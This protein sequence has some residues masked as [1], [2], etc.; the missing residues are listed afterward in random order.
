MTRTRTVAALALVVLLTVGTAA[1]IA[2]AD[3]QASGAAPDQTAPAFETQSD[4]SSN[5]TVGAQ[6][7][8]VVA[9]TSDEVETEFEDAAFEIEYEAGDDR[10]RADTVANRTADLVERANAVDG[11]YE[12][13][14]A[15]FEAGEIDRQTYA[16][17]VATLNARANNVYSS[18]QTV[19]RRAERLDEVDLAA[20]GTS[21]EEI[22]SAK[23]DLEAVTGPGANALFRQFT[24]ERSGE[25]EIDVENGISIEVESE[26]GE[27]SREFERERSG[28][29]SIEVS[30]S[31]AL[32]SAQ[33]G[34]SDVN[35]T[36]QPTKA[37]AD[38]SD[39]VYEFEFELRGEQGGE[40]EVSVDAAT[41][42][43]FELEEEI[44]GDEEDDESKRGEDE[45]D[46]ESD[47]DDAEDESDD[48]AE[49][50]S[51]DDAEDESDDDAE[52]EK[53]SSLLL[54]VDGAPE[55]GAEITL[56]ALVDGEPTANVTVE[57][58]D[59]DVGM[60]DANGTVTVVLP[61][62][63][64]D[65]EAE[66]GDAEAEVELEFESEDE[67]DRED[68]RADDDDRES[69]DD[70]T[71]DVT[72][73]VDGGEVTVTATYNGS[74]VG[75]AQVEVNGD[76]VGTTD[77]NGQITVSL[78]DDDEL[79][80]DVERGELEGEIGRGIQDGGLT[81]PEDDDSGEEADED[82]SEDEEDDD[83]ADDD[84][85]EI[86]EEDDDDSDDVDDDEGDE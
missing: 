79:E 6:L 31:D 82:D 5:A 73:S 50:E 16:Q 41:G 47:D 15:A 64:G 14:S 20:A 59:G 55:P 33:E 84:D 29:G 32:S 48:D 23:A 45:A 85:E 10:E 53:A 2:A 83:A 36:W 42:Q 72:A 43:V 49:D 76:T 60:T 70:R 56:T 57:G 39:G 24:G 63:G 68:E 7:S 40:A 37:K 22:Q 13:V 52:D 62:D 86:E 1:P 66:V 21:T 26:D 17:R 80:I 28:N 46:D 58:P 77:E 8:T 9:A 30:Q 67:D 4:A 3:A 75:D 74:A 71:L 12:N 27:R 35:G 18:L 51:D 81:A 19:E 54:L 69:A 44:E 38:L 78:P 11:E 61:E 65:Y 25:F 34:L